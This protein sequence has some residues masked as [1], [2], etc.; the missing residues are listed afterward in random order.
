MSCQAACQ[1]RTEH[2][3]ASGRAPERYRSP[4]PAAWDAHE[5]P[6]SLD[7]P[8]RDTSATDNDPDDSLPTVAVHEHPLP[9]RAARARVKR[10]QTLTSVAS[11]PATEV[12]RASGLRLQTSPAGSV[13]IMPDD[14]SPCPAPSL[15][16][17]LGA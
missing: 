2:Q 4:S 8:R 11:T 17:P 13:F 16:T 1:R 6:S 7:A 9:H 3:H 14:N 5:L 12:L 10:Q 15:L